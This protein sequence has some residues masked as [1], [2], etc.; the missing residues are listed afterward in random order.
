[1]REYIRKCPAGKNKKKKLSDR[2]ISHADDGRTKN[3]IQRARLFFSFLF[4]R[5]RAG[6]NNEGAILGVARSF[7]VLACQSFV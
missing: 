7:T 5:R 1:M 6:V 2:Q 3:E 4:S